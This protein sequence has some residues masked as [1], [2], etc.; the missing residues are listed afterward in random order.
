M[1]VESNKFAV[2][3]DSYLLPHGRKLRMAGSNNCFE[4]TRGYTFLFLLF[5]G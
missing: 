1:H 2:S 4:H 5:E 3:I